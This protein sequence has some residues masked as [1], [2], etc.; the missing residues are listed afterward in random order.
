MLVKLR[1]RTE[2]INMIIKFTLVFF[3]SLKQLRH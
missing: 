2:Q 3:K 1:D